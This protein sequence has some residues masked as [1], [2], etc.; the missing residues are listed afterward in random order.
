MQI[1]SLNNFS[2]YNKPKS[3]VNKNTTYKISEHN[4]Q[5]LPI[6]NISFMAK[7][8]KSPTMLE[9]FQGC[10]FG[11]A[12]GDAFGRLAEYRNIDEIKF[13]F[14]KL[15]VQYIPKINNKY[16]ITDDT[17][18]TLFTADGIIK[19]YLK[20]AD[21]NNEPLYEEIYKSY[22]NWYKTQTM[23]YR[24]INDKTGLL[25]NED[26]FANRGPGTTCLFSLKNGIPGSFEN[27]INSSNTNGGIMRIAPIALMYN[28]NPEL[29]FTVSAKCAALTHSMP[30]AYLSAGF[31]GSLLS[32]LI[33]DESLNNAISS[34]IKF[35]KNYKNHEKTLNTIIKGINLA[36]S[37]KT[38]LDAITEI[39]QG[40][41]A[42]EALAIALY[43][44]IKKPYKFKDIL[45][46]ATNHNGDSDTT[47]SIAGNIAGTLYGIKSIQNNW[48]ENIEFSNLL[49]FYSNSIFNIQNK[50]HNENLKNAINRNKD[51]YQRR[52]LDTFTTD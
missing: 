19:S 13:K 51:V 1:Y 18:M 11:G 20:T 5:T 21:I 3:N 7:I 23:K 9:R 44:V 52:Q 48:V 4:W 39:G 32:C 37:D 8:P 6:S 36:K 43:S 17:Q 34:S 47:A 25:A 33:N 45:A 41:A 27:M 22:L 50:F 12:I 16:L 40:K 2:I 10:L 31:L 35:L 28:H 15:G 38:N 42:D 30:E 26:L 24:D 49:N 46:I 29:A 14:G